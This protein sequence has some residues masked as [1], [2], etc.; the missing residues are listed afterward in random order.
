[1]KITKGEYFVGKREKGRDYLAKAL[2]DSDGKTVEAVLEDKCWIQGHRHTFTAEKTDI[3]VNLGKDPQAGKVYGADVTNLYKGRKDHDDFGAVN[4][5]YKPEKDVVAD[6][7]QAMTKVAK[8]MR[9]HDLGF[10]LDDIVWEIQRFNGERYAGMY[11][12]SRKENVPD[13]IHLRPE[14]NPA[15]EYPYILHHELGHHLHLTFLKSKKL[16]AQWLKLFNTSIKVASVKKDMSKN[17]LDMLMDQEDL[18]S[19][20]KSGL[21]E[22]QALAFKWII[23]TIGSVNALT[24][25]DLDT[26]FEAGMKDEIEKIWPVRNI[27]RKELAPVIS[28]YATKNVKELIAESYSFYM[29]GKKLPDVVVKLVERSI[30]YAKANREK[31]NE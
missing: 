15:T 11:I 28:D 12:K 18:P 24:I 10:L 23:R 4:F 29:I 25:K 8:K 30:S 17:L 2:S 20:F 1:M 7:W 26:L 16:N 19:D 31:T 13:R 3:V 21:D 9:K 14:S 22:E 5:F 27:P 6:L